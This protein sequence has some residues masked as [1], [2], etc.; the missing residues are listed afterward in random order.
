[1]N[2]I[3]PQQKAIWNLIYKVGLQ[4]DVKKERNYYF[5]FEWF[6]SFRN[7]ICGQK[8][9]RKKDSDENK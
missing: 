8:V 9:C 3:F 5:K 2:F 7:N 6:M 4:L 1:M